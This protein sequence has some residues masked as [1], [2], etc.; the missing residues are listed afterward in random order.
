M[1]EPATALNYRRLLLVG[2]LLPAALAW[3]NHLLLHSAQVSRWDGM[4]IAPVFGFYVLQI[5]CVGW[6]V[7]KYIQ[8]WPL[9]WLIYG[10]TMLLTDLQLL[11]LVNSDFS[12]A[13]RCLS[14][15]IF[16]GQLSLFVVWG[17]MARG[18]I[19]WRLPA[20]VVLL[21]VYWSCYT[22]LIRIGQQS[23]DAFVS[24]SDLVVM[25]T[26]LLSILCGCLR[27]AGFSLVIVTPDNDTVPAGTSR[28]SLQFG[29]RDVLIGTTSLALLLA[30]A[31][32]GDF[33]TVRYL[34]HIYD[35]GFLFVFTIAISTAAVLIVAL[36]AALGRGHVLV[37][38]IT[39][40]VASLAVGGP[41]GWYCV[42]IGQP[43]A[44]AIWAAP[45]ASATTAYWLQHWYAP[46]YWW[47]GWMFLA[48]TL[49]AASLV[50]YRT[51]GYRLVRGTGASQTANSGSDTYWRS[52]R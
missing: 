25:Q 15:G 28:R 45:N 14:S 22:M 8:P 39:L 32:A 26:V 35:H 18:S 47:L 38:A 1:S 24:W 29:I 33:L 7:A 37:R 11:V 44:M 21:A 27:L 30:V 13:I 16:A 31:K 34:R 10:W 5:G 23:W 46:G 48:G 51:L 17:I 12:D 36:W 50:I 40:L 42:N 20:L 9:R 41:L 49:L 19:G 52:A 43:Q 2:V 4:R 6:A 3:A